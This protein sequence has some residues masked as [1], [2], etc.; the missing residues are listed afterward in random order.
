[1]TIVAQSYLMQDFSLLLEIYCGLLT[2]DEVTTAKQI[3]FER[4]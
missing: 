3:H 2:L 4:M 1:M